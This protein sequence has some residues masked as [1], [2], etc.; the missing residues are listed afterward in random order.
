MSKSVYI[1][2]KPLQ[3]SVAEIIN[4]REP[5]SEVFVTDMFFN[6]RGIFENLKK[7]KRWAKVF[8][9]ANRFQSFFLAALRKPQKLY[10]DG[11]IGTRLALYIFMFKVLSGCKC[12]YVYEEGIGTYRN[13]IYLNGFKKRLLEKFGIATYFGGSRFCNGVYVF[14]PE[15]YIKVHGWKK[16]FEVNLLSQSILDYMKEY[17]DELCDL[18]EFNEESVTRGDKVELYITSYDVDQKILQNFENN[19]GHAFVK[20]HPHLKE[21]TFSAY[22]TKVEFVSNCIP[23]ELFILKLSK[24]YKDV[25]IY[26]HGSSV[27]E[28]MPLNNVEF[29]RI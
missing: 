15:L 3:L 12:I 24:N 1:I 29:I 2:S 16:S 10:I 5:S 13:D 21:N 18:Y 8:F 11:D 17:Y 19:H 7:Q 27:Q 25:V 20:L 9:V 23:A 14:N 4:N 22:F 6:A 26:H 28:Y